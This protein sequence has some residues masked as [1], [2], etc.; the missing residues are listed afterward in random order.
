MIME[1]RLSF[2]YSKFNYTQKVIL[3][4]VLSN[5]SLTDYINATRWYKAFYHGI[6]ELTK[7]ILEYQFHMTKLSMV[8]I[9]IT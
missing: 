4:Y 3:Y 2:H 7:N 5:I 9:E 1:Q 8:W 6:A